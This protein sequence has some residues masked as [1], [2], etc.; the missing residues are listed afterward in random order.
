MKWFGIEKI[1]SIKWDNSIVKTNKKCVSH[2]EHYPL[3]LD[4]AGPEQ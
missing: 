1:I 2:L 4:F 3:V